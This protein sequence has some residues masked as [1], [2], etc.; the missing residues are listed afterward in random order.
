MLGLNLTILLLVS[1]PALTQSPAMSVERLQSEAE[2]GDALAQFKLGTMYLEGQGIQ[3]DYAE[4]LKW[5]EKAAE[6]NYIE[7]VLTSSISIKPTGEY[8]VVFISAHS[9]GDDV[10]RLSICYLVKLRWLL[11]REPPVLTD[12]FELLLDEA[13]QVWPTATPTSLL[14]SVPNLQELNVATAP[15]EW[16]VPGGET[17]TIRLVAPEQFEW[18]YF[19]RNDLPMPGLAA[20]LP[21]HVFLLLNSVHAIL[22]KA[23]RT[24]LQTTLRRLSVETFNGPLDESINGLV[25]LYLKA[26]RILQQARGQL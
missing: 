9:G 19:V 16:A 20:N 11:E 2:R 24:I 7:P 18:F 13:L 5:I 17:F 15:G 23:E 3:Q 14:D 8:E 21:W 10:I 4:A 12:V 25:N 1:T 26:N 22:D 6:Q